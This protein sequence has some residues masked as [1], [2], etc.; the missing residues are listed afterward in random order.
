MHPI[1]HLS[2]CSHEEEMH[3]RLKNI[4]LLLGLGAAVGAMAA[5]YI[6]PRSKSIRMTLEDVGEKVTEAAETG[7]H[8][9]KEFVSETVGHHGNSGKD[10]IRE[11]QKKFEETK[12]SMQEQLSE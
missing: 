2:K 3:M 5:I 4:S 7:R 9:A 12:D 10:L 1:K 11:G 8:K 6:A